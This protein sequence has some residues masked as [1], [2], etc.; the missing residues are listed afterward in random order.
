MQSYVAFLRAVNVGGTGKLSM[1][2]LR[3]MCID[4]GLAAPRTYIT[5]G[6]VVFETVKTEQQIKARLEAQLEQYAGKPIGVIVRSAAEVAEVVQRNPFPDQPGNHV[7]VLF[8]DSALPIHPMDGATGVAREEVRLGRRELFIHYPDGQAN[9]RLR[10]PTM[11]GGT[12]R[13]IN[14]VSKLHAM[15]IGAN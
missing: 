2:S 7:V 6:N 13:N 5:S 8:S 4:A 12:A 11:T 3:A 1:E 14:T 10:L 15:L 9:T